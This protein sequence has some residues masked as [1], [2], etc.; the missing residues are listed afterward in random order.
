M[1]WDTC[2]LAFGR[3]DLSNHFKAWLED[4]IS[5]ENDI[6]AL[7]ILRNMLWETKEM[8]VESPLIQDLALRYKDKLLEYFP[9]VAD[10]L[11][12]AST[13]YEEYPF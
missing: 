9:D 13:E 6:Y 1:Y 7:D 8:G 4:M 3:K 12:D 5:S 10:D 2:Q 11:K